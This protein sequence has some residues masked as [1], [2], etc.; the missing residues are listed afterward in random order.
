VHVFTDY[1]FGGDKGS[2]YQTTDDYYP[3]G[4]Y[5]NNKAEGEKAILALYSNNSCIIRTSWVSLMIK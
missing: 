5:G 4:V 3:Q 1:V 2:P